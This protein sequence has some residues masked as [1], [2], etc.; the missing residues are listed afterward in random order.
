LGG[1]DGFYIGF[2]V[3]GLNGEGQE[4]GEEE[5]AHLIIMLG[6]CSLRQETPLGDTGSGVLWRA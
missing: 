4:K 6:G 3:E 5:Q 2:G 1:E